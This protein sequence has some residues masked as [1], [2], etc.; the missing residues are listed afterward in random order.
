M[1]YG[2][3]PVLVLFLAAGYLLTIYLLLTLAKSI[4]KVTPVSPSDVGSASSV[5]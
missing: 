2:G 5:R 1:T 3:M 4:A